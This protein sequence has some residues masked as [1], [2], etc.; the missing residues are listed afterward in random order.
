MIQ[1]TTAAASAVTTRALTP[2]P[3]LAIQARTVP[4]EGGALMGELLPEVWA[5]L[6]RE[7][8]HP[9]GPPFAR[10]FEYGEDGVDLEAGFP[11]P[12]PVPGN[13]RV[14]GGELPGGEAAVAMHVGHYDTLA[15]TYR[16][17]ERWIAEQGRRPAGAPWEVYLTDPGETPDP[18]E[19]R[20]EVLWP[21]R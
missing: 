14:R 12:G 3:M 7:G 16:Q 17:L 1:E 5:Y 6:E 4:S 19:W 8:V 13:D 9:A 2:Q 11:V 20:T 21:V 18:A 15:A 10:Y